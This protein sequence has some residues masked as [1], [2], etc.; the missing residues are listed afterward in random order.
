MVPMKILLSAKPSTALQVARC[1]A[2]P[3]STACGA[4]VAYVT[5]PTP[6]AAV[7][8]PTRTPLSA[9]GARCLRCAPPRLGVLLEVPAPKGG[10]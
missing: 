1:S 6:R 9:R 7:T 5:G 2:H 10:S 8:G 3:G 4:N